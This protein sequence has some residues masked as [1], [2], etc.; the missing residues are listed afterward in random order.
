M[1]L[2]PQ[3]GMGRK[4]YRLPTLAVPQKHPK[5]DSVVTRRSSSP[6]AQRAVQKLDA[7]VKGQIGEGEIYIQG[8]EFFFGRFAFSEASTSAAS[9]PQPRYRA[10][11]R[12]G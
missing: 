7:I 9:L 8:A 5:S 4:S 6:V 3:A 1:G 2:K 10:R 12:R 11:A